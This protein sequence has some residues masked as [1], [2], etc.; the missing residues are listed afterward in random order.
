V[1]RGLADT[2]LFIALESGRSLAQVELPD[3]LAISVVTIGELRAGVVAAGDVP[4][5]DLRLGTLAEALRFDAVPIDVPVAET[6]VRPRLKLRDA[7][8]RLPV[9]DSWI[10]A[11]AMTLEVPAVTQDDDYVEV[12]GLAVIR[13]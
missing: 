12:G 10:A 13:V 1:T 5:R 3:E 6:W 7:G 11:T 8:L 4:T 9:N 2:S